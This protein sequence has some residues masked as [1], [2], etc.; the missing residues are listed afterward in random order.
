[1]ITLKTKRE[2]NVRPNSR[3]AVEYHNLVTAAKYIRTPFENTLRAPHPS[4]DLLYVPAK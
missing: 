1:M 3:P 4:P 2:P